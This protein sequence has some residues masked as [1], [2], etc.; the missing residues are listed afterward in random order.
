VSDE[1]A[2]EPPNPWQEPP[3]LRGPPEALA[4]LVAGA[5]AERLLRLDWLLHLLR[6]GALSVALGALGAAGLLEGL[7]LGPSGL[8]LAL[9]G[10]LGGLG[11]ILAGQELWGTARQVRLRLQ[12][13]RSGVDGIAR[14]HQLT[15]RLWGAS[16]WALEIEWQ[17]RWLLLEDPYLP[18][19][20]RE[21]YA[22]QGTAELP[23]RWLEGDPH[24]FAILAP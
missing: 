24:R 13:L 20:T 19:R 14:L 2:Q 8:L 21:L 23:V 4:G 7:S 15:P 3:G 22:L 11:A 17:G 10:L 6:L 1:A 5:R 9:L 12:A 16:A 18:V